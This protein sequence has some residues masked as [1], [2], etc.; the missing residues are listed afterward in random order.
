[1]EKKDASGRLSTVRSE[2]E[3]NDARRSANAIEVLEHIL[4]KE[5]S[6]GLVLGLDKNLRGGRHYH[7]PL[8]QDLA[9]DEDKVVRG[10]AQQIL[11][12]VN[13]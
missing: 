6:R 9:V 12:K 8:L 13:A 5:L 11:G 10:F 4:P 3:G 2:L 1:L 7:G